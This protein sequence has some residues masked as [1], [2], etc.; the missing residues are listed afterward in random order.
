[1]FFL[2]IGNL[3]ERKEGRK[4]KNGKNDFMIHSF[5]GVRDK[6]KFL[7]TLYTNTG[8]LIKAQESHKLP[9]FFVYL[10]WCVL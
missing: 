9:C 8:T 1:M 3:K 4:L 10:S 7:Y 2:C 6:W 5:L